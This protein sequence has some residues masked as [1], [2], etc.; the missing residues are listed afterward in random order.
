VQRGR[1]YQPVRLREDIP[2]AGLRRGARGNIIDL[3]PA[4]PE[5]VEVEFLVEDEP[6]GRYVERIVPLSILELQ[7]PTTAD[8]FVDG[9]VKEVS[10]LQPVLDKHLAANHEL[11]PHVFFGDLT[12]FVVSGFS[13]RPEHRADAEK[14]LLLLE[15]AMGSPDEDVQNLVS[16]SFCENLTG[17]EPLDAIRAAMGSRLRAELAKYEGA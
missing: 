3:N 16:V 13:D 14:I 9:L 17:E 6:V 15:D 7:A 1:I 11:L 5:R 4:D 8:L 2:E 10:A 12:R